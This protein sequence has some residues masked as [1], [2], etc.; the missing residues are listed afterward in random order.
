M[1]G[2]GS[3]AG[4]ASRGIGARRAEELEKPAEVSDDRSSCKFGEASGEQPS[5]CLTLGTLFTSDAGSS[6]IADATDSS[7]CGRGNNGLAL[8]VQCPLAP[9][10]S[11][12]LVRGLWGARNAPNYKNSARCD[13]RSVPDGVGVKQAHACASAAAGLTCSLTLHAP[14][15]PGCAAPPTGG[16][17]APPPAASFREV[18][19]HTT[20][21]IVERSFWSKLG[22]VCGCHNA[23]C[24]KGDGTST[25]N[26]IRTSK[27]T[28]VT[29]LPINLFEQFSRVANLYFL[30]TAV[31]GGQAQG[32]HAAAAVSYHEAAASAAAAEP[33]SGAS[34]S[35]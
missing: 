18:F 10:P 16:T 15:L 12:G 19:L 31:G 28:L 22:T 35:S 32:A 6:G 3:S 14:H 30:L 9:R 34:Y 17:Q 29:F 20:K 5:S 13:P 33:A 1:P 26:E 24:V 27:Y 2:V 8:S 23:S 7:R 11:A 25:T 4:G 21:Q